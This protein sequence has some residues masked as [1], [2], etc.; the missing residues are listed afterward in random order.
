M[1]YLYEWSFYGSQF[2]SVAC[3]KE[4]CA[5]HMSIKKLAYYLKDSNIILQSDH[6]PLRKLLEKNTLNLN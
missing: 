3:T 4:V 1:Q 5:I 2:H 6:L